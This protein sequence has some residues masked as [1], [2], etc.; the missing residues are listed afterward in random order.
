MKTAILIGATGLVG[1]HLLDNLISDDNYNKIIVFTRRELSIKNPKLD[2]HAIDFE[3]INDWKNKIIGDELF[4]CLGTTIKKAGSKENQYKVD[5]T[6]QYE[7]AKAAAKNGIKQYI[8][9]SSAGAN[10]NSK[11]FYLNMKGKLEK[12]IEKLP[13]ENIIIFQP[14]LLIGNRVEPRFGETISTVIFFTFTSLLPFIKKYRPI[15]AETVAIAMINSA[16]HKQKNKLVIFALDQIFSVA[17][18]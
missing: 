13:F 12:E 11:N 14:S 16:N 5:F 8:L 7:V 3:M 15:N 6:Y 17:N 9:V 10:Y 2:V 18:K 4:S 1:A